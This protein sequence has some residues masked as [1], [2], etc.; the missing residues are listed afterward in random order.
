[1]SPNKD[2]KKDNK[3]NPP[4]VKKAARIDV[5]GEDA[6][7]NAYFISHNIQV[8]QDHH[9]RRLSQLWGLSVV[10]RSEVRDQ[11]GGGPED[12]GLHRVHGVPGSQIIRI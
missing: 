8:N 3:S 1:M 5:M 7:K 6:M 11:G 9:L 10:P 12:G 4:A 2:T